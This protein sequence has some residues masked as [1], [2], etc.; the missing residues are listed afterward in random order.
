V[1]VLSAEELSDRQ[2]GDGSFGQQARPE[3][4]IVATIFAA[5]SLQEGGLHDHPALARALDFLV[6]AAVVD[7]GGSIDGRRESV[8]SCYTGMLARLLVRAGRLDEAEPLV[9]WILRYQ[10][11]TFGGAT[12]HQPAGPMWGDYLRRRYGGCMADTTCLLGLVPTVSALVAACDVG[13][14]IE[15]EPHRTAMRQLLVD[16]RVMFGRSGAIMPLAGSTKADPTGT[17]W[18][19]PAFPLDYVCDLIELVQLARQLGVPPDAMTEAVDLIGSWRLPGGGWP[20]LGTRRLADA[21]RPDRVNRQRASEIV[22]R[23]VAALE[24]PFD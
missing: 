5:R 11:V 9:Q 20:L 23:R 16:R 10:P 24:L 4:R 2:H 3:A 1:A 13:M 14:P 15:A 8:L 19:V 7:G 6:R 18:L 21:Y 22:T 17:R 12:Y